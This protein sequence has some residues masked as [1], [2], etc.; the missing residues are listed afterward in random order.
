MLHAAQSPPQEVLA[1]LVERVTFHDEENGFCVLRTKARGQRDLVT[2]IGQAASISAGK[3]IT[4]N[5]EWV[6]DRTHGL[7]F[8]AGR[9][10]WTGGR[11]AQVRSLWPRGKREFRG[12]HGSSV[13]LLAMQDRHSHARLGRVGTG[14]GIVPGHRQPRRERNGAG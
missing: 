10:S 9:Q 4:A 5:G 13:I 2:V 6:N 1:G 3:W 7:Q 14:R 11:I 8:K 12:Q